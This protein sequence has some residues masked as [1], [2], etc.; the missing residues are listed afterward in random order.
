MTLVLHYSYSI[1]VWWSDLLHCSVST[2]G[3]NKQKSPND[4]TPPASPDPCSSRLFIQEGPVQITAVSEPS[5]HFLHEGWE[6]R[7]WT[8]FILPICGSTLLLIFLPC[9]F[10]VCQWILIYQFCWILYVTTHTIELG[11]SRISRI[12]LEPN[13]VFLPTALFSSNLL[14]F[15]SNARYIKHFAVLFRRFEVWQTGVSRQWWKVLSTIYL[16]YQL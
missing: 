11:Y 2:D 6:S 14:W 10:S 9:S 8:S 1:L 5:E 12:Q 13:S 15:I 16:F 4:P 3:S 7:G